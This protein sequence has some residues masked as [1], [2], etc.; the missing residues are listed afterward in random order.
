MR[1]TLGYKIAILLAVL[2]IAV[3]AYG[4]VQLNSKLKSMQRFVMPGTTT[5]ELAAGSTTLWLESRSVVDGT[6]YES[7]GSLDYRCAI[8]PHESATIHATSSNVSYSIGS[9]NGHSAF[10]LE[11]TTAGSY[12]L[13]CETSGDSRFV[14]A[15]GDG[16]GTSIVFGVLGFLVA[17]AA[18]V[19]AIVT[20]VR[21]RRNRN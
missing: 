9:Y 16:I 1:S 20:F 14:I 21:R 5:L 15:L 3:A 11:I 13:T 2:G 19:L 6:A 8:E 4:F 7:S 17:G 12:K 18:A 10:D